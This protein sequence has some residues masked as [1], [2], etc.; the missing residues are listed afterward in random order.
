MSLGR[1][2]LYTLRAIWVIL[3]NLVCIP[4]YLA[5]LLLV[6]PT[7]LVS[8]WIFNKVEQ[9]LFGWQLTVISSWS[10]SAGYQVAESGD[11]LDHLQHKRLLLLPNHQ[12][13]GDVPLLM[14]IFT[15]KIGF[16]PKLMWVMDRA[17]KFTNFGI[18]SWMHDDF[19]IRNGKAHRLTTLVELK[20]HL[21]GVFLPKDRRYMVLF[22]EGGFLHK[23][24]AISDQF[25]KKKDLPML[26]NCTL[27]R[28][29]AMD[30]IMEV[31]GPDSNQPGHMQMDKIVD[32][33][34]AFPSG[35]PLD[36]QSIVTGWRE[37]FVT[38]VHYR[39]FDCKDL[40]RTPEDLFSWMVRLYQEKEEMLDKY[41]KTGV[42]PY[43]MFD[44]NA[45]PPKIIQHDPFRCI[46]IHIFFIISAIMFYSIIS[47]I[48]GL[49]YNILI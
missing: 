40:P 31:L 1:V 33:T 21:T 24:K 43:Q 29:G 14:S 28:T 47:N 9:V 23:R 8:P 34:V 20:Q 3:C 6:S 25:A 46:T 32:M 22:P 18:P 41:Y 16:S 4:S 19:F 30:V 38:H 48:S 12:H 37:P 17:F 49:I 5:W 11:S 36:L 2:I 35:H 13:T 26:K 15:S 45:L 27:P 42:F 7:C 39:Q 44:K 10:I